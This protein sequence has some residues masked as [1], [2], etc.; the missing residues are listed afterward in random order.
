MYVF[1]TYCLV[2]IAL[3]SNTLVH[4]L[5]LYSIMSFMSADNPQLSP[6]IS[7]VSKYRCPVAEASNVPS[8]G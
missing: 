8:P 3:A 4:A 6:E 5:P 2:E 7:A 1:V